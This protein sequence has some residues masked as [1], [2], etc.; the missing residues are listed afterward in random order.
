MKALRRW[1]GGVGD[2]GAS[3]VEFALV[4]PMLLVLVFGIINFGAIF[5]QQIAL[6]NAARQAARAAVVAGA[7]ATQECKQIVQGVQ[8]AAA[9]TIAMTTGN[10]QSQVSL[11]QSGAPGGAAAFTC[12]GGFASASSDTTLV[13]HSVPA[14]AGTT[15]YSLRI[16]SR[17]QASWLIPSLLPIG[18]PRLST[19]A[20]YVCE[21]T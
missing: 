5:A 7:S 19:T 15:S 12:S 16:D 21:F 8:T 18:A 14:N 13:C 3:A 11:V 10:I 20:V 6:N 9:T 1:R 17:Y 2:S 4:V